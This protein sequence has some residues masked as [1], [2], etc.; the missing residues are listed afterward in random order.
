[1]RNNEQNE[2]VTTD[3]NELANLCMDY[4]IQQGCP[5]EIALEVV[6]VGREAMLKKMLEISAR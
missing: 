3:A 5:E 4:L 2:L 1:M 6:S